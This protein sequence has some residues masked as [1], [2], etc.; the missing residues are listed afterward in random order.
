MR[1]FLRVNDRLQDGL[2]VIAGLAIVLNAALIAADV[3]LRNL[4]IGLTIPG[5]IEI[6]EYTLYGVLLCAAPWALRRG[7]HIAVEIAT[8][9]LP[10]RARRLAAF[11]ANTLGLAVCLA[12]VYAGGL[13]AWKAFAAERLVFKTFVFPEWWLL[14]PLPVGA[15]L[16]ALE[17]VL[18]LLGLRRQGPVQRPSR[19]EG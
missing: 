15:G 18:I 13:A 19:A 2:A 11:L 17:F 4:G 1:Q 3:I 9:P 5:V 16:L 10:P 6:T 7:A 8:E 14:A 12:L